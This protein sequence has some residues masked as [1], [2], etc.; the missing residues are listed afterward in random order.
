MPDQP[1]IG[2]VC[3]GPGTGEEHLVQSSGRQ[4]G[5][6]RSQ[7]DRG[8]MAGLE[9]GV[10]ERQFA[11]LTF[12]HFG[13]LAPAIADVHAPKPGHAVKN[14]LALAVGQPDTIA[15]SDDT[16]AF[17]CKT[18]LLAERV[19]VVAMI[20]R[21]QFGSGTTVGDR[22]GRAPVFPASTKN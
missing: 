1:D 22:H 15:T 7:F 21:L 5:Q 16:R 8:Y 4:L 10:I 13:Q 19:H 12:G 20:Q 18:G 2:V 11:H 14:A 9:E 6:F 3:F 17:A